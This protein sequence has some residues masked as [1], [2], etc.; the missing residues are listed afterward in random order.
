M[1][2]VSEASGETE[3]D[4]GPTAVHTASAATR[5]DAREEARPSAPRVKKGHRT[6]SGGEEAAG[7]G[8]TGSLALRRRPGRAQQSHCARPSSVGGAQASGQTPWPGG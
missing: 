2:L 6:V 1:Q 3:R 8:T 4:R 5:E 7:P